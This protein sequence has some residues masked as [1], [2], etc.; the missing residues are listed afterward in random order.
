M[1]KY[2][3]KKNGEYFCAV[4]ASLDATAEHFLDAAG[5]PLARTWK[6]PKGKPGNTRKC[7][8]QGALP[9][10][11]L[12]KHFF[13]SRPITFQVFW[14]AVDYKWNCRMKIQLCVSLPFPICLFVVFSPCSPALTINR[15]STNLFS[16]CAPVWRFKEHCNKLCWPLETEKWAEWNGFSWRKGGWLLQTAASRLMETHWHH[17]LQRQFPA[18]QRTPS[19]GGNSGFVLKMDS[20]SGVQHKRRVR[21]WE[22]K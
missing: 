10:A 1:I 8:S 19:V 5:S 7:S 2:P 21:A 3:L 9:S 20:W 11:M 17:L 12:L 18:R 6:H 4:T 22:S 16:L 15:T 14:T 13:A